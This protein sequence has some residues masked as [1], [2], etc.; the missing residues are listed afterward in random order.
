MSSPKKE[1]A[2]DLAGTKTFAD[3]H[4]TKIG[5]GETPTDTIVSLIACSYRPIESRSIY[6]AFNYETRLPSNGT[7]EDRKR[8]T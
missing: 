7:K 1:G 8:E 6:K 2:N 5:K 4:A 3:G